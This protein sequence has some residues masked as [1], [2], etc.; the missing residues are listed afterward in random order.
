LRHLSSSEQSSQEIS[1]LKNS[2]Y[3]KTRTNLHG[4]QFILYPNTND[5]EMYEVI[6]YYRKRDK[7]VRYDVLFDDCVDPIEVDAEEMMGMLED[8]HFLPG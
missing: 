3:S 5:S 7:T 6:G 2:N 4:K 1:P 8:S